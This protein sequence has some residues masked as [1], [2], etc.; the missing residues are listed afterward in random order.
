MTKIYTKFRIFIKKI[1][2]IVKTCNKN[3]LILHVSRECMSLIT[4]IHVHDTEDKIKAIYRI[5]DTAYIYF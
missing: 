4:D 1:I 3:Q 2:T 5:K